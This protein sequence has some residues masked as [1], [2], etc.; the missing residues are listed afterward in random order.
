MVPSCLTKKGPNPVTLLGPSQVP[1]SSCGALGLESTL[2]REFSSGPL[3]ISTYGP[4][5]LPSRKMLWKWIK[6]RSYLKSTRSSNKSEALLVC[7][8]RW[9]KTWGRLVFCVLQGIIIA[10]L[11]RGK[12]H[13]YQRSHTK[14][15][16]WAQLFEFSSYFRVNI[17]DQDQI[18][19]SEMRKGRDAF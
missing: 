8:G 14:P 9:R 15:K 12:P 16:I 6:Y 1:T 2:P 3:L 4:F 17:S 11:H 13:K 7:Q 10:L 18:E 19:T 5:L